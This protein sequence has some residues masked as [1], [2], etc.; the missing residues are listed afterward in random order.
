MHPGSRFPPNRQT[1]CYGHTSNPFAELELCQS[2]AQTVPTLCYYL[3]KQKSTPTP[4]PNV[5]QR[6]YAG[7][8]R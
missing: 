5:S 6:G 7:I 8:D 2:V 3:E 4:P 1:D